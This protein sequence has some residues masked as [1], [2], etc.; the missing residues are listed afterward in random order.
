MSRGDYLIMV[1]IFWFV[2]TGTFQTC[3][4]VFEHII[5]NVGELIVCWPCE[6]FHNAN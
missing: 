5:P 2:I 6:E 4:L 3:Q 1:L